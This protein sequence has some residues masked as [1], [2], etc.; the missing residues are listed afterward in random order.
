[1]TW[2]VEIGSGPRSCD[3]N[4]LMHLTHDNTQLRQLLRVMTELQRHGWVVGAQYWHCRRHDG[5]GIIKL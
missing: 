1:M 2:A 3:I 5:A 4:S